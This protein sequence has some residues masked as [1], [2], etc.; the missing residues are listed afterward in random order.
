MASHFRTLFHHFAPQLPVDSSTNSLGYNSTPS[1]NN[2]THRSSDHDQVAQP[3]PNQGQ[4]AQQPSFQVPT[5]NGIPAP[6]QQ[7]R[8]AAGLRDLGNSHVQ[9][10]MQPNSVP[11]SPLSSPRDTAASP[12]MSGKNRIVP[13]LTSS[14]SEHSTQEASTRPPVSFSNAQI[15]T[16]S[17]DRPETGDPRGLSQE[18]LVEEE[19]SNIESALAASSSLHESIFETLRHQLQN[20]QTS[21]ETATETLTRLSAQLEALSDRALQLRAHVNG[22]LARAVSENG[23]VQRPLMPT[24]AATSNSTIPNSVYLLSSPSGPQAL[25]V[26]PSGLY[27]AP[28]QFSHFASVESDPS[29][30]QTSNEPSNP[31]NFSPESRSP[32]GDNVRLPQVNSNL[33]ARTPQSSQPPPQ[34]QPRMEQQQQQQPPP[35]AQ[36]EQAN[37]F[38][39][40]AR[41]LVPMGG[42]IWLL[43]RLFGFVY[44]FTGGGG[45]VRTIVL[46]LCA[47]VVFIAQSGIFQPF[48]QSIWEPLRR[49]MENLLPLAAN[50]RIGQGPNAGNNANVMQ[51]RAAPGA[52]V[53]STPHQ[54]A[55]RLLREHDR[56]DGSVIRQNLRRLERALALFVASLVPGVGERHIAARDAAEAARREEER[57]REESARKEEEEKDRVRREQKGKGREDGVRDR[58]SAI[59]SQ[60]QDPVDTITAAET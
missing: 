30:N 47:L 5:F 3:H 46:G 40:L 43:V 17:P 44:F 8:A 33:N 23:P 18:P 6:Q 53:A 12:A 14:T 55:E 19:L 56:G 37:Q 4:S 49:H 41:A 9:Q 20:L 10:H 54:T 25:L 16:E 29:V 35:P 13:P 15:S 48:L 57:L 31:R 42:H 39:D 36:Q 1:H 24:P 22:A 50:D 26:S 32:R 52:E 27:T 11:M 60:E 21:T 59:P 45:H 28:W 2:S 58:E 7:V 38:R 34:L 51:N